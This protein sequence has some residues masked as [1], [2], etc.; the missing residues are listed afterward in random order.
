MLRRPLRVLALGI[1]AFGAWLLWSAS[2][3]ETPGVV[4]WSGVQSND[5][6]LVDGPEE[7]W[8]VRYRY[9]ADGRVHRA[10]EVVDLETLRKLPAGTA[11]TVHHSRG[12]PAQ[13][14]LTAHRWGLDD[15]VLPELFAILVGFLVLLAASAPG[16]RA[17][18]GRE[19]RT[20]PG[21]EDSTG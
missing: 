20:P 17:S 16:D 7:T 5:Q 2:A 3:V 21:A 13:G 15:R 6:A 1:V 8:V 18:G 4:E 9:E 12:D 19:G 14:R 11:V 10:A